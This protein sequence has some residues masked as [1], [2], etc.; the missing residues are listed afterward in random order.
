VTI[1]VIGIGNE[2][3]RDDGAGMA[4]A[5]TIAARDLPGVSVVTGIGDPAAIIEAW[6]DVPLVVVVDAVVDPDRPAGSIIRWRP[7]DLSRAAA[8]TVSSHSVGLADTYAL[9]MAIGRVPLRLVGFGIAV[10]DVGHGVGLTPPVGAAIPVLVDVI[11][12]ELQQCTEPG[13]GT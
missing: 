11:M 7:S 4:I 1:L 12:S 3:R 9:G 2:F 8:G 10:S 5:E 13:I 6:T